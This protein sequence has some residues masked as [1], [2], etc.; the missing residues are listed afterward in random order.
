MSRVVATVPELRNV[1]NTADILSTASGSQVQY[2]GYFALLQSATTQYD[3]GLKH[4]QKRVI[5]SHEIG[6]YGYYKVHNHNLEYSD[7]GA[8]NIDTPVSV[9]EV[10]MHERA[11]QQVNM[12]HEH[13][14]ALNPQARKVWDQ[15]SDK[16]KVIILG[17]P[18]TG[19]SH[20]SGQP[21]P[22]GNRYPT[23]QVNFHGVE[24]TQDGDELEEFVDA[25]Q[26]PDDPGPDTC[27]VHQAA[28]NTGKH[29]PPHDIRQVLSHTRK[30][31]NNLQA[32][33]TQVTCCVTQHNVKSETPLIDQGANGCIAG[34]DVRIL[35][36]HLTH[37]KVDIEGIDN[38]RLNSL[39]IGAVAGVAQSHKGYVVAIMHQFALIN[40]GHSIL[41]CGQMEW[42]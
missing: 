2:A 19:Q 37:C 20:P 10:N 5:Y 29:L 40:C 23:R 35:D 28:S 42:F 26:E 7:R 11:W 33:M 6:P 34:D 36:T 32:K 25:P 22:R 8:Y 39:K 31:G 30:Y 3:D 27:Q 16:Q 21:P 41:S 38:H 12:P 4:K 13:W 15:L 9:I 14:E 1:K 18:K 24:E 17:C